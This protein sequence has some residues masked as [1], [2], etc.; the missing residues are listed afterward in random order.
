MTEIERWLLSEPRVDGGVVELVVEISDAGL[1]RRIAWSVD[2][3]EVAQQQTGENRVVLDGGEHGA[4]RLRLPT[5]VGPARRVT[6]WPPTGLL[7]EEIEQAAATDPA[8]PGAGEEA[9]DED[10][11]LPPLAQAHLGFGGIDFDPEPG[12]K[13]AKREEWIRTHPRQFALRRTAIAVA[14]VVIPVLLVWLLAR[15]ALPAIPWP[16]WNIPWPRIP[17]PDWSIPWPQIPWPDWRLPR[18]DIAVPGWV[19]W[20]ADNAKFVIPVVIALFY[21]Q[22]EVKRRR[23]Q[24]E[25]KRAARAIRP[26]EDQT[27][28]PDQSGPKRE[29]ESRPGREDPAAEE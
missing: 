2:G 13:A 24:D 29:A 28:R 22:R 11:E 12:S 9:T 14:G 21:A 19:R 3:E 18:W 26:V 15:F 1:G 17:W 5:F 16:S 23:D 8:E 27:E 10:E 20:I 7:P 4:L 25:R 6:W